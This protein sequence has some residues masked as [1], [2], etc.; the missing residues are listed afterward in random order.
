MSRNEYANRVADDLDSLRSGALSE[1][2]FRQKYQ[3]AAPDVLN[4]ILVSAWRAQGWS[5]TTSRHRTEPRR[6]R[7]PATTR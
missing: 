3:A 4:V 2:E 5:D 6:S 7:R 1:S